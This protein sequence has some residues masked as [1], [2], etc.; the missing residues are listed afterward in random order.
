MH[1]V[2]AIT[3]HFFQQLACRRRPGTCSSAGEAMPGHGR[4]IGGI[5]VYSMVHARNPGHPPERD[6]DCRA[7]LPPS[8]LGSILGYLVAGIAIGP[9]GAG[10]DLR[11]DQI[12]GVSELG[13]IMLLFL[14]GLELR[15]HRLWVCATDLRPRPGA[16]GAVGAAASPSRLYGSPTAVAGGSA[17]GAGLALSSTAIVLP[18]LARA[19]IPVRARQAAIALPCCC[20]RTSSSFRWS[21][22]CRCWRTARWRTDA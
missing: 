14:I 22:W 13:V 1:G 6:G 15:P 16:D 3:G 20:F 21:R 9:A 5:L 8:G 10:P 7:Y 2:Q 19:R 11:F 18:M 12:A 4:R 17:L